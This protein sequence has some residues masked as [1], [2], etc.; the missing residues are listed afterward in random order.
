MLSLTVAPSTEVIAA[1]IQRV[2][3]DTNIL[4]P[5]VLAD[6]VLSS[7]EYGLF[8][9]VYS[10]DLIA[11][12]SRVLRDIKGLPASN[13]DAFVRHVT[14]TFPDGRIRREQYAATISTWSGPDVDDLVHLAAAVAGSADALITENVRDFRNAQPPEGTKMPDIWTADQYF[15]SLI[16]D[17]FAE[18]LTR[19]IQGMADRRRRPPAAYDEILDLLATRSLTT[20]VAL[21]RH[22]PQA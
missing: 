8:D 12:L 17:G 13:V 14:T 1:K 11:E 21:L 15:V 16:N 7:A 20:T 3:V 2:L 19:V 4:Y 10:D 5:V 22:S 6:L 18:D 9:L